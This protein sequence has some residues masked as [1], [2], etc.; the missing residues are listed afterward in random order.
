MR[1]ILEPKLNKVHVAVIG[2][3]DEVAVRQTVI[4]VRTRPKM[5]LENDSSE[6]AQG[7]NR[8]G[9]RMAGYIRM[10][11]L[12]N[13]S[14]VLKRPSRRSL[15]KRRSPLSVPK[16]RMASDL[17]FHYRM[18]EHKRVTNPRRGNRKLSL[19]RW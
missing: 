1:W 6:F 17:L 19:K 18:L 14:I 11:P 16:N 8:T 12:G 9:R 3:T 5:N 7:I 2:Y 4:T 15:P 13:G 10:K